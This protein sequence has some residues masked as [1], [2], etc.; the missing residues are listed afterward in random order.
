M[1]GFN[2][3]YEKAIALFLEIGLISEAADCLE[4]LEQYER[5]ASQFPAQ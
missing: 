5:V 2:E 4:G 3:S 1:Q